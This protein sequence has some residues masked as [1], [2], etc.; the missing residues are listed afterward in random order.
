MIMDHRLAI[1]IV[2][3]DDPDPVQAS[4]ALLEPFQKA[5]GDSA[6]A[7]FEQKFGGWSD[8]LVHGEVG[9]ERWNTT[10]SRSQ[11]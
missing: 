10:R 1:V 2:L 6:S 3:R 11:A 4:R 9:H 7:G 8:G 5:P